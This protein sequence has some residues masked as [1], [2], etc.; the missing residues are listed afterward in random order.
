M[1]SSRQGFPVTAVEPRLDKGSQVQ[2]NVITTELY[3]RMMIPKLDPPPA[4][5]I[6]GWCK[7]AS[8]EELLGEIEYIAKLVRR[9]HVGSADEAGRRISAFLRD[10]TTSQ[11]SF[12]AQVE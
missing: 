8:L 6:A 4:R 9:G 1:A 7:K 3:W 2:Q 5:Y 12:P 11:S 10:R